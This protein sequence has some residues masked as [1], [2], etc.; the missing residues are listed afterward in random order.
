M[1]HFRRNVVAALARDENDAAPIAFAHRR[2]IQP[3]E[4]RA[5]Q[6]VHIEESLPVGVGNLLERLDLEDTEVVHQNID[7]RMLAHQGLRDRCH[8]EVAGE[9]NHVAFGLR[10][11]R[12]H[13]ALH[14]GLRPPIDDDGRAFARERSRDGIADARGGTGDQRNFLRQFQIHEEL[15][16][17]CVA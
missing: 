7:D 5:A 13:G 9:S 8:A 15:P 4:P 3:R 17:V 6:H 12:G 1:D 14:G 2:E 16:L 10:L 11:H